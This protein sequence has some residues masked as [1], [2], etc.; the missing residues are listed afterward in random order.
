MGLTNKKRLFVKHYLITNNCTESAKLAGYSN[1]TAYSQ[2]SRLLKDV[3]VCSEI[4]QLQGKIVKELDITVKWITT[5]IQKVVNTAT[6][7]SDKLRALEL[8]G[9]WK[10]MFKEQTTNIAVFSDVIG[11]ELVSNLTTANNRLDIDVTP[12][13]TKT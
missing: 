1:K 11:H 7:N 13:D 12:S 8:L 4:E 2:G 5:E 10:G 6:N 3:D 9:K